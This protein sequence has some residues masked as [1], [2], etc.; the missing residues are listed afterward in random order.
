[1]LISQPSLIN[2]RKKRNEALDPLTD[3][4]SR[5]DDAVA[6]LGFQIDF[7]LLADVADQVVEL[8]LTETGDFWVL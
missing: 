8:A 4:G 6:L 2:C 1:M 7:G 3:A 5:A